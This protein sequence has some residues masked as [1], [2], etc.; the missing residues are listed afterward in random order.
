[1]LS[2]VESEESIAH[3]M[4]P[5][6]TLTA[7]LNLPGSDFSSP[8]SFCASLAALIREIKRGTNLSVIDSSRLSTGMIRPKSQTNLS[9]VMTRL[10]APNQHM[11]AQ[12]VSADDRPQMIDSSVSGFP[13]GK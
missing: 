12:R 13:F 1:M 7:A 3:I 11:T 9:E 10:N 8:V 2:A 6:I 5:A 4:L